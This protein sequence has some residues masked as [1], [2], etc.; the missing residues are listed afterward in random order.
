[1]GRY[2]AG[3]W[4]N[5]LPSGLL[6]R[7]LR[8][9][10]GR[11]DIVRPENFRGPTWSWTSVE[12]V[13]EGHMRWHTAIEVIARVEEVGCMPSNSE[14]LF[15]EVAQGFIVLDLPTFEVS[16][17]QSGVEAQ[18]QRSC[19]LPRVEDAMEEQAFEL[20]VP[21]VRS[22]CRAL[23]VAIERFGTI[24]FVMVRYPVLSSSLVQRAIATFVLAQA[25]T[26]LTGS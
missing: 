14:N 20:D 8:A 23:C 7:V 10:P 17:R 6:W 4:E 2:C 11:N 25:I 24:E 3:L 26:L 22:G 16:L 15:G 1:M 9:R 13:I 19:H 21:L 5:E 18:Q 12:A